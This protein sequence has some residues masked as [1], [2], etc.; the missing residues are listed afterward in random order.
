MISTK[1]LMK[2]ERFFIK[3]RTSIRETILSAE[4]TNA[5]FVYRLS[6]PYVREIRS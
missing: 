1:M 5:E 3:A 2:A 6:S 4:L